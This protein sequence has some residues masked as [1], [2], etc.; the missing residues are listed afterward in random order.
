[1]FKKEVNYLGRIISADGYRVDPSN[2]KAVLALKETKPKTVGDVRKLLGLLGYYRKYI[3]DFSRIAQPLFELLKRPVFKINK[4]LTQTERRS[5]KGNGTQAQSSH[6]IVWT[7][8]LVDRL[9]NPPILV[10]PDYRL[11]FVLHT[12]ASNEGLGAVHYQRQSG[13][14]RVIGYGSRTLTTAEENYHHSGK[15]EFLALK[16]AVCEQFRDHLYYAP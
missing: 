14:M 6:A 9:A 8:E 12:D 13:K 7:Q 16:W 2:V 5:R 11:P 1:M 10:Y 15:L 3:Q 4:R